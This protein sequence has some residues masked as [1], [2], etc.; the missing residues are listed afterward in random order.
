MPAQ[1]P[2]GVLEFWFSDAARPHWFVRSEAFDA[3][4][5]DVLGPLH[6]Q[7][8]A[9]Q[10]DHW[11]R[12]PRGALALVILLDQVPRNIHRGSANAFATDPLALRHARDA[13]DLGLDRELGED[14]RVFLYLPFEH[15]ESLADQDRCVTL[16]A[17][18]RNPMW[19][20]YAERHRQVIARFGRFPHRNA[21]LGRASSDEELAF[22]T[23]P[24]SSF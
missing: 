23:Q 7:A 8:A 10:L 22:L 1:S 6:T 24:G 15:S 4:V 14:E 13:V 2:D 11:V 21:T 9:G 16:M 18:L 12:D 20:D 5:R 3:R 17:T 19:L